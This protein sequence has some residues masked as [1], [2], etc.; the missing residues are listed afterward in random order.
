MVNGLRLEVERTGMP[1][2]IRD[3]S[4]N[5]GAGA[6]RDGVDTPGSLREVAP[7]HGLVPTLAVARGLPCMP[8]T[9]RVGVGLGLGFGEV[10]F[11]ARVRQLTEAFG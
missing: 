1:I 2:A 4:I 3:I 10:S 8:H 7:R 6:S 5:N 9:V 11:R